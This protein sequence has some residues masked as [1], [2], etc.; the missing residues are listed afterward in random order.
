M[1]HGKCSST[2][3]FIFVR[4]EVGTI[5]L[6]FIQESQRTTAV[7]H[8]HI[9]H[10]QFTVNILPHVL[11]PWITSSMI[12]SL[13]FWLSSHHLLFQSQDLQMSR[14]R[15]L[16]PRPPVRPVFQFGYLIVTSDLPHSNS[17]FS[18]WNLSQ[19]AT[20][21]ACSSSVPCQNVMF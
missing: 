18:P 16:Q 2:E 20:I 1:V 12:L 13:S 6:V 4:F 14:S 9:F 21:T 8:L 3:V 11:Y 5:N 15:W 7:K 17:W 19:F 10:L